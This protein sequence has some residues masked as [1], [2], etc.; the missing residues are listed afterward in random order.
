MTQVAPLRTADPI[1]LAV[2]AN[3]MESICRE[4]MN[5]LLRSARSAVIN[6]ARDFSC[7][8]VTADNELLASAEGLPI[9][10]IGTQFMAEAMTELH[11]LAE[12]DA[13]I[14][15][16]P[17]LGNSHSADHGILVPVFIEGEHVFTA[18]AKA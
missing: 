17:Y 11:E 2:M 6:Q 12:G 7:S 13:F 3:R 18:V 15:N 10:V 14:H 1:L 9:H 5:T 16:D 8:I 4:M